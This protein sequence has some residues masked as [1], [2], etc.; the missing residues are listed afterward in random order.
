MRLCNCMRNT[1]QSCAVIGFCIRCIRVVYERGA[2]VFD[3]I[4]KHSFTEEALLSVTSSLLY[5]QLIV[6]I[7]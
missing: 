4:S 7:R 5:A 3:S 2:L 1:N 6:E